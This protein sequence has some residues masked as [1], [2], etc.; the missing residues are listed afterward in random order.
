MFTMTAEMVKKEGLKSLTQGLG[1]SLL[2]EG[3]YSTIRLGG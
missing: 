2:R 3:T 1:A